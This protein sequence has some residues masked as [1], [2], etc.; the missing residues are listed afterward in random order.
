M[1]KISSPGSLQTVMRVWLIAAGLAGAA[2]I[3][4]PAS[5]ADNEAGVPLTPAEAAGAWTLETG[6]HHLCVLALGQK[7]C[8]KA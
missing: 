4:H 8:F 6:A 1:P 2:L 5:A 3:S 7:T